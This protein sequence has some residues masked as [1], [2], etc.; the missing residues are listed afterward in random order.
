MHLLILFYNIYQILFYFVNIQ[1]S[2]YNATLGKKSKI[3]Q[4]IE[5]NLYFQKCSLFIYCDIKFKDVLDNI[6]FISS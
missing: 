2:K 1:K 6:Y 4:K 5:K 3:S